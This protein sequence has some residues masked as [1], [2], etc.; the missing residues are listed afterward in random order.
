MKYLRLVVR[1]V[2]RKRAR[3]FLTIASIVLVL[4][5]IVTLSSLLRSLEGGDEDEIG[6][7]RIFVHHATG[8]AQFLPAADRQKIEAVEGVVAVMPST[9]FGGTYIDQRP[10]NVF[11]QLSADPRTWP[12]I[13]DNYEISKEQLA[14]WQN[15]GDSF[16][17][18][19]ALAL[20][21]GWKIGDRIQVQGSYLPIVLDL[22]LAGTFRGPDE[23]EIFFHDKY[24]EKTW[25]GERGLTQHFTLRVR[26]PEDVGRVCDE[27]KRMFENSSAPVEAMSDKAFRLAFV[28]MLGNVKLLIRSISVTVLF[29]IILIVSNTMAMSA[30]ERVTEIAVLKA[31][32]FKRRQILWLVLG[33]AMFLA[34]LGGVLGVLAS[35]PFTHVLVE[36]MKRSPAAA[37][38][39]NFHVSWPTVAFAFATSVAIGTI[40]GFIPALRSSRVSVVGALR[41][42]A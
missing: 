28:E 14:A 26:R 12:L 39:F 31:L 10:E 32:G 25:L 15:A 8:V 18:H 33:E 35:I 30:R 19:R 6:A 36:A 13:H 23:T 21:H 38:A 20:R 22:V 9:W 5:L 29:T 3:A 2:F 42:V 11:A 17:A 34:L 41:Q 37:F 40:S 16:I 27:I 24:L 7:T 4:I 1:N